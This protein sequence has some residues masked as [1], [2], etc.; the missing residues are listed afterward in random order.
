MNFQLELCELEASVR[1]PAFAVSI[2]FCPPNPAWRGGLLLT[3]FLHSTQY[4]FFLH[5]LSLRQAG[6]LCLTFE[7]P[8]FSHLALS[9]LLRLVSSN[10]AYSHSVFILLIFFSSYFFLLPFFLFRI[11]TF[12][13]YHPL[14]TINFC[15]STGYE[16]YVDDIR[17]LTSD[18][19]RPYPTAPRFMLTRG[20]L[21]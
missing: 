18:K 10:T 3:M 1:F 6:S 14:S 2:F 21:L 8:F 16:S 15:C 19:R 7:C 13:L 4:F 5:Q 12:T 9:L 11:S 20:P 17:L